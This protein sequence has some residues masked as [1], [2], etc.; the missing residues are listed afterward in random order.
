M[1]A[2]RP[3]M[4]GLNRR[5]V[6]KPAGLGERLVR[7]ET[8]PVPALEELTRELLPETDLEVLTR[9]PDFVTA[10]EELT[11]PHH[12]IPEMLTRSFL[13]LDVLTRE[14]ILT[15]S[16]E[17][18]TDPEELTREDFRPDTAR[19]VDSRRFSTTACLRS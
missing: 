7:N 3:R 13:A 2:R 12:P 10:T 18:F 8:I 4:K 17:A 11:R 16:E 1:A 14:A 19:G 6:Y 5:Q 9:D 15:L